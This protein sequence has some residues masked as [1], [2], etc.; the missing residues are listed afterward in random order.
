MD[1]MKRKDNLVEKFRSILEK[2]YNWDNY[3]ESQEPYSELEDA[4]NLYWRFERNTAQSLIDGYANEVA[5]HSFEFVLP[6]T[7][8][9]IQTYKCH[10]KLETFFSQLHNSYNKD[11]RKGHLKDKFIN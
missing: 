1:Q 9:V 3:Q 2:D 5:K 7:M 8:G 4:R 11:K 6:E 10:K